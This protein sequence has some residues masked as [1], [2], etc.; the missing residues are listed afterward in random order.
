MHRLVWSLSSVFCL[1]LMHAA[2]GFETDMQSVPSSGWC[3]G[4]VLT[5]TADL[6][7]KF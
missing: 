3:Y 4:A 6:V 5:V 7:I 1:H 2:L